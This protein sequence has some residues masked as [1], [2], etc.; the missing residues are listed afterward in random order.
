MASTYTNRLRFEKQGDGENPNSWGLI[1]NQNVIDLVDDAI[2]GYTIVSVS[3]VPITLTASD[4]TADQ[5][6][7]ASLEI[8]GTLTANVTITIPE[9]QKTYFINENTAGAFAV[10]LKTAS[11][12]AITLSQGTNIFVACDGTNIHKV[13]ATETSVSAFTINDLT[14]INKA[15]FTPAISGTSAVFSGV[16][17]ANSMVGDY[18]TGNITVCATDL[19]VNSKIT[20]S[21]ATFS[22]TVSVNELDAPTGSFSTKVSTNALLVNG[23]VSATSAV[24][25]GTV[26]AAYFDGDGSNLTN[27]PVATSTVTRSKLSTGT[28]SATGSISSGSQ[29]FITLD[30]YSFFPMM[31]GQG[32]RDLRVIVHNTTATADG[33]RFGL[34]N[35]DADD[36]HDY[37]IAWRYIAS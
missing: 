15:E 23:V 21:T 20:G 12:S 10:Q 31:S 14:V 19:T 16:V 22:G 29:T 1:L 17:S 33:P 30:A 28:N 25:S 11:G 9:E 26:S 18:I 34:Y 24:F 3:S 36:S 35:D 13:D 7:N 6:R 27:V 2:A 8:Q 5:S 37:N 4:G 32:T